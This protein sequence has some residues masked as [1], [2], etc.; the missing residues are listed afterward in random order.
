MGAAYWYVY[1][2]WVVLLLA[3]APTGVLV[4]VA[5]VGILAT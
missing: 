4:A 5:L 1:A 2:A 3:G